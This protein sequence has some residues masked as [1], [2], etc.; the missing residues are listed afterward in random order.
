MSFFKEKSGDIPAYCPDIP[1][2]YVPVTPLG[3]KERG[4]W[5]NAEDYTPKS[6]VIKLARL[7]VI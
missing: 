3:L 2:F 4:R 5:A 7:M 1:I 6:A